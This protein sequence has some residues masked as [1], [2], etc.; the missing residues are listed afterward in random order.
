M[1]MLRRIESGG[2]IYQLIESIKFH[3][4]DITK[5]FKE[6]S[7]KGNYMVPLMGILCVRLDADISQLRAN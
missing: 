4:N 2:K 7:H 6:L 5:Q 3:I 1:S